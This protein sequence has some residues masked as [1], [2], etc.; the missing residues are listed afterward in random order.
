MIRNLALIIQDDGTYAIQ[1]IS[2]HN[3][4]ARFVYLNQKREYTT[5]SFSIVQ[6][7]QSNVEKYSPILNEHDIIQDV[8]DQKISYSWNGKE[9]VYNEQK[10]P[11]NKRGVIVT[12]LYDI[13]VRQ[14]VQRA[15]DQKYSRLND[16]LQYSKVANPTNVVLS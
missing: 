12:R 3:Q 9:C 13:P 14:P 10:C 7:T 6:F 4:L 5:S 2:V 16:K 15:Q 1:V 11:K 8:V